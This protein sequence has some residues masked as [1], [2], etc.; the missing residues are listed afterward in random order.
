MSDT[1]PYAGLRSV[2]MSA[3]E[4]AANGKGS[5]RHGNGLPFTDQPMMEIGRMTGAGGPAF[6]AMKKSQEALG[7]IRR[8]QDKAAEAE[9][10][11]AINYLAGA[12]LLI[13]EGRA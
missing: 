10:L 9:L 4:Q 12:I 8:G 7:M 6:Q 11:G 1:P 5:D 13:R 3:L 2:L